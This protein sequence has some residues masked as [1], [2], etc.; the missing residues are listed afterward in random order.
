MQKND[1]W[2][3]ARTILATQIIAMFDS[4]LSSSF[5]FFAPRRMG[6]TEFLR[7]DIQ[8]LAETNGW[9]VFYFSFLDAA[10]NPTVKFKRA[11]EQY[12]NSHGLMGRIKN[13]ARK[14]AKVSAGVSKLSAGVEFNKSE[15]IELVDIKELLGALAKSKKTLLLMDEVQAL[16]LHNKNDVFIASFR[17]ALDMYKDHL[18]VIFTGSSQAGLRKMFSQAKAPFFHFGQ[19]LTFPDLDR[20]FTDHLSKVFKTVTTRELS[21]QGLW[22]AFTAMNKVPL[23]A[24]SLVERMAL[25]PNLTI[26]QAK[27]ELNTEIFDNRE[28]KGQWESLSIIEQTILQ[29]IVIETEH[30]FSADSRRCLALKLNLPDMPVP[31]L[32]ASIKKLLRKGIIG[33]AEDRGGYFVDDPNFKNWL[34][35]LSHASL[36]QSSEKGYDNSIDVTTHPAS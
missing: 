19:N 16:A 27:D 26:D 6:K 28:F 2:H 4:G 10:D 15:P 7:K 35:T 18:K 22:D 20:G 14:I 36:C 1:L 31:M 13:A 32:Q 24:R 8:P 30:L 9:N 11:L 3:Y 21:A 23:L 29:E 5:I 33:K 17:T 34:A 12:L 25:N